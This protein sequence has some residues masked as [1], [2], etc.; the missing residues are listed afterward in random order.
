MIWL[1]PEDSV[2]F[3]QALPDNMADEA[4]YLELLRRADLRG[5]YMKNVIQELRERYLISV[6]AQKEPEA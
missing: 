1:G 3:S 5:G 6:R 2:A 4:W